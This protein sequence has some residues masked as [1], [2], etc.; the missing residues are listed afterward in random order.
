MHPVCLHHVLQVLLMRADL[1]VWAKEPVH[2]HQCR[3]LSACVWRLQKLLDLLLL[4]LLLYHLLVVTTAVLLLAW[5]K[6]RWVVVHH[7]ATFSSD[8]LSL[9]LLELMSLIRWRLILLFIY[10]DSSSNY[11]L[12][13][14]TYASST[15]TATA[16][17]IKKWKDA[18][19][20]HQ[21]GS[22]LHIARRWWISYRH[23]A[24]SLRTYWREVANA[25][26]TTI[27]RC[28]ISSAQSCSLSTC[29]SISVSIVV[30]VVI[31]GFIATH[32]FVLYLLIYFRD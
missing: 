6:R 24:E 10:W 18:W 19:A 31:D 5:R 15:R 23:R 17:W 1:S 9:G 13:R 16:P 29:P 4:L 11:V 28:N 26:S 27:S 3:G 7:A 12:G 2:V 21:S 22:C 25:M 20:W 30:A 8:N 14:D 32:L